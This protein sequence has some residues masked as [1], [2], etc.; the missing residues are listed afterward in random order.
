MIS[1]TERL[2]EA[3]GRVVQDLDE[4]LFLVDVEWISGRGG[5]RLGVYIA[6]KSG[7]VSLDDCTRVTHVLDELLESDPELSSSYVLEVSSPGLD[8]VIKRPEEYDIFVGRH[9]A[10]YLSEPVDEKQEWHG[11]LQGRLDSQ[12]SVKKDDGETV[13]IPLA[14]INK[15]KLVF[16]FK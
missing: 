12:V 3:F 16:K 10:L 9:I 1:L 4:G 7:S 2:Y 8:R 5:R 13:L 15:A 6:R 14:V 11:Q